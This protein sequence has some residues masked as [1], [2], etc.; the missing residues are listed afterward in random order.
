MEQAPQTDKDPWEESLGWEEQQVQRSWGWLTDLVNL[1]QVRS[2]LLPTGDR[3]H[4]PVCP[5]SLIRP[6]RPRHRTPREQQEG[7]KGPPQ[8]KLWLPPAGR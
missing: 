8:T 1:A 5:E 7:E 3:Y 4:E 2:V 6:P